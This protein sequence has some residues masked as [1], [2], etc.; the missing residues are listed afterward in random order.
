MMRQRLD[1]SAKRTPAKGDVT[2]S[3]LENRSVES[4]VIP[5]SQQY[6][7]AV[8]ISFIELYNGAIYDLLDSSI[9]GRW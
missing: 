7:Y 3:S 9:C 5:I 4:S 1:Y 6:L 8:F 2:L